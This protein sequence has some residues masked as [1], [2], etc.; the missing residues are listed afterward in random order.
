MKYQV[1]KR[2]VIQGSTWNVGDVVETGKDFHEADVKGLMGI[3]RIVPFNEPIVED[4]SIGL[5][6]KPMPKRSA[7]AKRRAD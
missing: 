7:R 4:R 6:D 3:G 1:M 5:D 2:C